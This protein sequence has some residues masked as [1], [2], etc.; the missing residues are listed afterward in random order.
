MEEVNQEQRSQ[1]SY[2]DPEWLE[3]SCEERRTPITIP[4]YTSDN[5]GL[6]PGIDYP[7]E[8]PP[9]TPLLFRPNHPN[10]LRN[11]QPATLDPMFTSPENAEPNEEPMPI[12]PVDEP[13]TPSVRW[14][15]KPQPQAQRSWSLRSSDIASC[16]SL[17]PATTVSYRDSPSD[18]RLSAMVQNYLDDAAANKR[19]PVSLRLTP[20]RGRG[21]VRLGRQLRS[22]IQDT[23][24]NRASPLSIHRF[25]DETPAN[26]RTSILQ[27]NRPQQEERTPLQALQQTRRVA[28]SSNSASSCLAVN[29]GATVKRRETVDL[30]RSDVRDAGSLQSSHQAAR[31]VPSITYS[32][33]SMSC[34]NFPQG[35]A[36]HE[37]EQKMGLNSTTSHHSLHSCQRDVQATPKNETTPIEI[38]DTPDSTKSKVQHTQVHHTADRGLG[39][40]MSSLHHREPTSAVYT[41]ATKPEGTT[42]TSTKVASTLHQ[43]PNVRQEGQSR[44]ISYDNKIHDSIQETTSKSTERTVMHPSMTEVRDMDSFYKSAWVLQLQHAH[45]QLYMEEIKAQVL[46]K[47]PDRFSIMSAFEDADDHF[48]GHKSRRSSLRY[49]TLD[50]EL[51]V[52]STENSPISQSVMKDA[53]TVRNAQQQL[54]Y[55]HDQDTICF[56]KTSDRKIPLVE[57]GGHALSSSGIHR[58]DIVPEHSEHSTSGAESMPDTRPCSPKE[59]DKPQLARQVCSQESD[60]QSN[61][62]F[63]ASKSASQ[64]GVV[65]KKEEGTM[66]SP[67]PY[68]TTPSD[69]QQ[70]HSTDLTTEDSTCTPRMHR[71]SCSV[72]KTDK[73][74]QIQPEVTDAATW[75][76][77]KIVPDQLQAG[78]H[79]SVHITAD[80]EQL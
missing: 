56:E 50:D 29:Q 21:T 55:K 3:V 44:A 24:P 14:A 59:T 25:I 70:T 15:L 41:P 28:S 64:K 19:E 76:D 60:M 2:Y 38:T 57:T 18:S 37:R 1:G 8:N 62:S 75:Y 48:A 43:Q 31:N 53:K 68:H 5:D 46:Y 26:R 4:Q 42:T 17:T 79:A 71:C 27:H 52:L 58:C 35:V 49:K 39:T 12:F 67:N 33:S 54:S 13:K 34:R 69:A 30:Q 66:T 61:S 10:V 23:P 73:T 72:P 20:A 22:G 80:D 6:I 16:S 77:E 65:V 32:G 11:D 40:P 78:D 74:C 51:K 7:E 36:K 45:H 63:Q 47:P 9:E